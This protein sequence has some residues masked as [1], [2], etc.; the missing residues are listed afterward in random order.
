LATCRVK[1]L[2][3]PGVLWAKGES[4]LN[5]DVFP[6]AIVLQLLWLRLNLRA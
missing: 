6:R 1:L 3:M 4:D 2:G 5:G